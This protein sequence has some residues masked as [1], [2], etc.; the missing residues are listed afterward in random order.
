[1]GSGGVRRT[2]ATFVQGPQPTTTLSRAAEAHA[3]L[4]TVTLATL[5]MPIPA[6]ERSLRTLEQ[7]AYDTA[8]KAAG[9][10][11][12]Q[13]SRVRR[14]VWEIGTEFDDLKLSPREQRQ[15]KNGTW[16]KGRKVALKR[17]AHEA[18]SMDHLRDEDRAAA[19]AIGVARGWY[20]GE[21]YVL[22]AEGAYALAGHPHVFNARG[23]TV[24]IVRREPALTL[25][26]DDGT[27]LAAIEP[28]AHQ[29]EPG[30]HCGRW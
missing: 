26:E 4:G 10:G 24:E 14:L 16:T 21:E 18:A 20:G 27:L 19:A 25:D 13:A 15:N 7:Y 30:V 28:R 11:S 23:E 29:R 8:N 12:T 6:W 17:L 2:P 9:A 3:R 5:A 22:E 1:M